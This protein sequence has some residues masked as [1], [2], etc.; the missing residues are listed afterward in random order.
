MRN[1]WLKGALLSL[2]T[3]TL[4]GFAAWG[5]GCVNAAIQRILISTAFD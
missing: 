4:A 5:D 3:G 1:L 2:M